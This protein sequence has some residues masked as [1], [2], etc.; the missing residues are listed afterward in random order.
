MAYLYQHTEVVMEKKL[1]SEAKMRLQRRSSSMSIIPMIIVY[2]RL[3]IYLKCWFSEE[4]MVENE[5]KF[6]VMVMNYELRIARSL[7]YFCA[8]TYANIAYNLTC[9]QGLNTQEPRSSFKFILRVIFRRSM[10][11]V[12]VLCREISALLKSTICICLCD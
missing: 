4:S 3:P 10:G 12:C 7:E 9:H 1:P 6:T 2:L 5:L 8:T 11:I